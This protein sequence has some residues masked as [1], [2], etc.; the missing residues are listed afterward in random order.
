MKT[1]TQIIRLRRLGK[2]LERMRPQPTNPDLHKCIWKKY[3]EHSAK[4]NY[5]LVNM[6][7]CR[8]D[9]DGFD[10]LCEYYHKQREK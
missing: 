7:K 2:V 8:E 9:C 3:Q 10:N 4:R 5:V 6:T 1:L